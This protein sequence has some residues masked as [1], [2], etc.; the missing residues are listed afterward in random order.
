MVQ[1]VS[2]IGARPIPST[3]D[4]VCG[5][6]KG[7]NLG[8]AG[9]LGLNYPEIPDSCPKANCSAI[10]SRVRRRPPQR[11]RMNRFLAN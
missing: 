9:A 1:A 4:S 11:L 8:E 10:H 3:A 6:W 5:Q 2:E 7:L